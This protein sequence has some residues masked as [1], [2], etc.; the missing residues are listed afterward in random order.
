MH[1]NFCCNERQVPR[2]VVLDDGEYYCILC[3]TCLGPAFVWN[4]SDMQH[5]KFKR[6]SK[7]Y[8]AR[9]HA[10]HVLNC[11]QCLELNKPGL[12]VLVELR[13]GGISKENLHRNAWRSVRKHLTYIW[14]E[15]NGVKY[16]KILPEHRDILIDKISKTPKIRK[17]RKSYHKIIAEIIQNHPEMSYI[18]NYLNLPES[19]S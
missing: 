15:L 1:F 12:D 8:D 9:N 2:D 3:G 19:Q 7:P 14:C 5:Y 6:S 16:L 13:E 4:Y 10:S 17:Q 11:L 18:L